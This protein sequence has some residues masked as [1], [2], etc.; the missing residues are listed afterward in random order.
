MTEL[1]HDTNFWFGVSFVIFLLLA[2]PMAK[3][4][5][6]AVFDGYAQK[7]RAELEEATRLRQEAETLLADARKRQQQARHDAEEILKHAAEQIEVLRAQSQKD[8]EAMLKR[9]EAQAA[10]H[11]RMLEEQASE[12]IRSYAVGRA[13]KAAEALL[14]SQF[15]A[16]QDQSLIETQ[17][18][19]IKT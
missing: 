12:E 1:L 5:V 11:L 14:Q 15:S 17:I 10:D 2:I 13:L 3:K 19:Q 18:K 16:T 8:L 6:A 9:R 7:I 4:P